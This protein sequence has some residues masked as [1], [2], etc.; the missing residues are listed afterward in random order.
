MAEEKLKRVE[1]D[2]DFCVVGG[3]LAGTFAALSAARRGVRTVLIQDRPMPGEGNRTYI[4][5]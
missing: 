3:G 1:V 5:V 2:C 4:R